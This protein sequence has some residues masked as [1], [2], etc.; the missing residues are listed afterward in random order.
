MIGDSL[1]KDCAP[2]KKLGL[3]TVWLRTDASRPVPDGADAL[4]DITIGSLDQIAQI[5]W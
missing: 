4:A 3:R 5:Q 1:L 2:A